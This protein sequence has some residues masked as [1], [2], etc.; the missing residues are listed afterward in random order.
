LEADLL[1]YS[2]LITAG[3]YEK[4]IDYMPSDFWKVYEKNE[5][6]ADLKRAG[7]QIDS[8]TVD[9]LEIINISKSLKSNSKNFRLITY[10]VNIEFG[11]SNV[12][13]SIIEKYKSR[14]GIDNVKLD[15]INNFIRIKNNSQI[16]SVY[17]KELKRWKYLEYDGPI[18]SKVY[19]IKTW[20][21]LITH[22]H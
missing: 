14:F 8:I 11:S 12:P 5:F 20:A 18:I 1:I 17:D 6:L 19:D 2:Q 22:I 7:K 4:A 10:S 3:E 16:V 9:N 21:K 15:T 13:K